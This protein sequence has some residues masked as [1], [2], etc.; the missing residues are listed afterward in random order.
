ML[1]RAFAIRALSLAASAGLVLIAASVAGAATGPAGTG[2][3]PAPRAVFL[4]TEMKGT[5]PPPA[6]LDGT[7]RVIVRIQG[8][9]VCFLIQWNNIVTPFTGHIHAGAAG[10]NGPIAVGFWSGQLP[11]TITGIT[12]CVTSTA[13][14]L[15]AIIAKPSAYYANVHNTPFPGGAIRGQLHR[16]DHPVDFT[17]A[18]R[19]PLTSR[20]TGRQE[21]PGP[22]DPD[23]RGTAF[24]GLRTTT[25][26][27]FAMTW[28]AIAAPTAAHVHVG[29]VGHAGAVVVPLFAAPGGLPANITGVAGTVTADAAVV[30]DIRRNPS[31]YYTNIH[32]ADFPAG[33]I[34]GQLFRLRG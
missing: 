25:T 16:L 28:T 6:D 27:R 23:G 14:T 29:A 5:N 17:R 10:V 24:I 11:A 1:N 13:A 9:Q 3:P 32:T 26:V 20:M 18:L 15:A 7:G 33:A 4:A 34:R 22:G 12:G 30:R 19:E 31:G 21:V 8:T 2:A